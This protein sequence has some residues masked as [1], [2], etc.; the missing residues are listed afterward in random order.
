M[1]SRFHLVPE[2]NGQTDKRTDRQTDLLYQY[3]ASVCWRAIKRECVATRRWKKFGVMFSRFETVPACDGRTDRRT[4]R[5]A[6]GQTHR[7]TSWDSIVRDMPIARA[8]KRTYNQFIRPTIDLYYFQ[9]GFQK[10]IFVPSYNTP[11]WS[12]HSI[13]LIIN[14]KD[15][16]RKFTRKLHAFKNKTIILDHNC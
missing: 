8:V 2:R 14:I 4:F 9:K 10:H 16:Q 13:G 15:V 12:P 3:R 5:H 6:D 11:V 1:L 7:Q